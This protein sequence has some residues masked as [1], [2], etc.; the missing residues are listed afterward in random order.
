M[1]ARQPK[2]APLTYSQARAGYISAQ[3]RGD[4]KAATFYFAAM[5]QAARTAAGGTP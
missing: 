2:P 5:E 3:A 1:F 4:N